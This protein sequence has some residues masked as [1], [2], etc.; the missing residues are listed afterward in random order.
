MKNILKF[1]IDTALF[2]DLCAIGVIGLF[3]RFVI[4]EGRGFAVQKYFLGLHRHQWGDIHLYLAVAFLILLF[5]HI[6][7]NWRWIIGSAKRYA[8]KNWRKFLLAVSCGWILVLI[9]GW[10]AVRF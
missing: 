3:L 10:V 2:V 5:F 8:G 4:P 6:W 9:I 1:L 7:L